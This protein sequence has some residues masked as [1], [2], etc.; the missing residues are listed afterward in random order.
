MIEPSE[1]LSWPMCQCATYTRQQLSII[2]SHS[3]KCLIKCLGDKFFQ[4]SDQI[5]NLVNIC[6]KLCS[7]FFFQ[8]F[9]VIKEFPRKSVI[10]FIFRPNTLTLIQKED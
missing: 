8:A 1:T 7:K 2:L 10:E 3:H 9:H 5:E 6:L 4:H